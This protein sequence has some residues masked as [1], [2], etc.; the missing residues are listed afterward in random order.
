MYLPAGRVLA[1]AHR[2]GATHP[3]IDGLENT[4]TAFQ[5]A[6]DLGYDYLETDVHVTRDGALLAFHDDVVDRVTDGTGAVGDLTLAQIRRLRIAGREPIPTLGE[7]VEAFPHARF[8]ID[9]K[10]E[11]AADALARYVAAHDLADRVL[12]GSFSIRRIREFR[13]R[14]A[15]AVPTAAHPW[16]ILAYRLSPTAGI[17]RRLTS[18]RCAALQLP[19]RRGPLRVVT[20]G[21]IRRAHAN[22][23]QV[24]VWTVDDPAQMHELLDLGVDGLF[25][26]RTDLLK[27]VLT[28]RGQW[29]SPRGG[30]R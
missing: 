23:V 20:A 19:A 10:S 16:E 29:W 30:D 7:L 28:T 8:N 9:L 13:R 11:R 14:T 12:V 4:L 25:T 1:F 26:D 18:R 21:L 6:W 27:D 5:H 17:A 15:A 2:G 22:G 24:H 3:E